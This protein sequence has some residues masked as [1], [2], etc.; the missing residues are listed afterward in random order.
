[1]KAQPWIK[2]VEGP[3][4]GE[5][6]EVRG[7]MENY[8]PFSGNPEAS[9]MV[10]VE[11][12]SKPS[13]EATTAASD[14]ALERNESKTSYDVTRQIETGSELLEASASSIYMWSDVIINSHNLTSYHTRTPRVI[15]PNLCWCFHSGG[16]DSDRVDPLRRKSHPMEQESLKHPSLA[17]EG[18][19]PLQR[20]CPGEETI[21]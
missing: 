20:M 10:K 13:N 18:Q 6:D 7:M 8:V 19:A 4:M 1:M 12:E 2:M 14:A 15:D 11:Y 21:H 17:G 3:T 9:G 16:V 5:N